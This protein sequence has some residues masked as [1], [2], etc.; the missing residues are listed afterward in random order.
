MLN[1]CFRRSP[2]DPIAA[3]AKIRHRISSRNHHIGNTYVPKVLSLY[4]L[5]VIAI[6]KQGKDGRNDWVKKWCSI[7]VRLIS[8]TELAS[9][10]G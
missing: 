7:H 6:N 9:L 4:L 1:F 10:Y 5:K 3:T 8:P 2:Q